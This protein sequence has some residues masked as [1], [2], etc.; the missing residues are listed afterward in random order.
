MCCFFTIL[1]FLGPRV[2][3][4]IWWLVNPGLWDRA[5]SSILW[6][7]LG[8]I[9]APWTTLMYV[10]VSPAG[11]TGFDWLWIGLAVIADIGMYAG[12]GYR[13]RD[14]IPGY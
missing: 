10:L 14:R 9:F 7:I 11:V 1:L 12:G 3:D 2:A 8:I 6:P 13:N 4:I 5:F